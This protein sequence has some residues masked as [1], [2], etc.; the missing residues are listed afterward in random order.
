[1]L[2]A[3]GLWKGGPKRGERREESEHRDKE[4][5]EEVRVKENKNNFVML[6]GFRK[7]LRYSLIDKSI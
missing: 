4:C 6:L 3:M 2:E 7:S 5:N 1:M